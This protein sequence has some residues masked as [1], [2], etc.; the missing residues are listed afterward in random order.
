MA[1]DL[2]SWTSLL[3]VRK[4]NNITTKL[5]YL[6]LKAASHLEAAF[7]IVKYLFFFTSYRYYRRRRNC[8]HQSRR[9]HLLR[10]RHQNLQSR[11]RYRR[12]WAKK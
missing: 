6:K 8:H 7:F 5:K 2:K 10:H 3:F 4:L 11:H 1:A 9:I 12:L